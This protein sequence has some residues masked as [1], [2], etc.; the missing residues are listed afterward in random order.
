MDWLRAIQQPRI[1]RSLNSLPQYPRALAGSRRRIEC[2]RKYQCAKALTQIIGNPVKVADR[3]H[4]VEPENPVD[5]NDVHSYL[6]ALPEL[7]LFSRFL[8]NVHTDNNDGDFTAA[9]LKGFAI[10]N[11]RWC[12]LN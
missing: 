4:S 11:Y 1:Q 2:R 8:A 5:K 9:A 3:P 7:E 10:H 6:V 12:L